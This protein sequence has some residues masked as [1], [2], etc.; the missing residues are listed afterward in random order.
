MQRIYQLACAYGDGVPSGECRHP[1]GYL[2]AHGG[3]HRAFIASYA[4]PPAVIVLDLDHPENAAYGQLGG[5][6]RRRDTLPVDED[7]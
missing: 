5:I 7:T 1:E 3:G 6:F 2:S 4:R